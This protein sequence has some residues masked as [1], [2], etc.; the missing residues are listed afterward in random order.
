MAGF[1]F[2]VEG[3]GLKEIGVGYKA[4]QAFTIDDSLFTIH[5]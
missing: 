3:L 2:K 1:L 4:K 5:F